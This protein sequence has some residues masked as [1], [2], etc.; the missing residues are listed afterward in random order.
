MSNTV[1]IGLFAVNAVVMVCT[2]ALILGLFY[3]SGGSW[4]SLTGL[5]LLSGLH[6]QKKTDD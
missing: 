6:F 5:V 4:W 3:M 2:T 1:S